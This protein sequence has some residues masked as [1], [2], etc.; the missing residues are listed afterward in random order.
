MTIVYKQPSRCKVEPKGTV[1][2]SSYGMDQLGIISCWPR[3]WELG[4]DT[5]DDGL[6]RLTDIGNSQNHLNRVGGTVNW[7]GW[8]NTAALSKQLGVPAIHVPSTANSFI[9]TAASPADLQLTGHVTFGLWWQ[10]ETFTGAGSGVLIFGGD[11]ET[12]D[13]NVLYGLWYFPSNNTI[14]YVHE[15]SSGSNQLSPGVVLTAGTTYRLVCTRDA[16]AKQV[17]I[18]LNGVLTLTYNYTTAPSGGT[19]GRLQLGSWSGGNFTGG[20]FANPFVANKCWSEEQVLRDHHAATRWEMF[21]G[22][23]KVGFLPAAANQTLTPPLV[24]FNQT[25]FGHAAMTVDLRPSLF[26]NPTKFGSHTVTP[27]RPAPGATITLPTMAGMHSRFVAQFTEADFPAAAIDGGTASLPNGGG[28]LRIYTDSSRTVR[29][30]LEV[31]KFV[32]GG[33]PDCKIKVLIPSAFTGATIFFAADLVQTAQPAAADF[34][35]RNA[36]H[37]DY[38]LAAHL[39]ETSGQVAI[40]SAGKRDG[41]YDV[42]TRTPGADFGQNL[43]VADDEVSFG[44]AP[45]G[46][47]ASGANFSIHI[48]IG[49]WNTSGER[50]MG[51]RWGT[52]AGR[53]WSLSLDDTHH[54]I[55][56]VWDEANTL[57]VSAA[58]STVLALDTDYILDLNYD[59]ASG[60]RTGINGAQESFV[61]ALGAPKDFDGFRDFLVGTTA[62]TTPSSGNLLGQVGDVRILTGGFKTIEH[63]LDEKNNRLAAGAWAG[64]S[65]WAMELAPALATFGQ[66]FFAPVVA[67]SAQELTPALVAFG[68]TFFSPVVAQ[69][70]Q[71]LTPALVAFGQTFFAPIVAQSAQELTPA[72][73]AFGQTFFSPVVAQSA[74]ELT[75]SLVTFSQTFF[76][77]II[78]GDAIILAP[79]MAVF[80]QTFFAPAVT[81]SAQELTPSLVVFSQTFFSPGIVVGSVAFPSATLH[82]TVSVAT[83]TVTVSTLVGTSSVG[84]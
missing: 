49:A 45:F 71:E 60:Y 40:D 13:T 36:V 42:V 59:P 79:T 48:K 57:I 31:Q 72:L 29:L 73:V 54:L 67:Q 20:F 50:I 24:T 64:A 2:L 69:S 55:A 38:V 46:D 52:A 7:P 34:Y 65:V 21:K 44:S 11:G 27:A 3:W 37:A 68:Q 32:T 17:K 33:T 30:P 76:T 28:S 18:Y 16:S 63:V 41:I 14:A 82:L 77:H 58:G 8:D 62:S 4:R 81:Q 80:G 51:A 83:H 39:E 66:T 70:A 1:E 78:S 23:D 6:G 9:E 56:N 35:G 25:F 12:P 22:P 10:P 19:L 53:Y 5:V 75:P 84:A 61:A 15:Y 74:Q 47:L 26:V 43:T